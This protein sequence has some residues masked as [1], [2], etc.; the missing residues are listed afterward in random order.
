MII[1]KLI[2]HEYLNEISDIIKLFYGKE[3]IKQYNDSENLIMEDHTV[4]IN[5]CIIK[6]ENQ[7]FFKASYFNSGDD[8]EEDYTLTD[9]GN[10][11]DVKEIKKALKIS[12]YKLLSKM[13]DKELP[14][15]IL[16]GIR[17]VKIVHQ[18][19]EKGHNNDEII[20]YLQDEYYVSEERAL[21]SVRVARTEEKYIREKN[22]NIISIYIGI[23]F[24]PSRCNYCSFTSNSIDKNRNLVQPY[25]DAMM[26]EIREVSKYLKSRGI[27]AQSVYIG[28][29]TPTSI[30]AE[31]LDKL[32]HC[33][34]EFWH[35]C[36]EFTCEA[37]RPDTIDEEKLKVIKS[38]EVTRLSIN[39]QTMDDDTLVRIGRKHTHRQI[40]ESFDLARSLGF[41]N[42][43]MDMILGLPGEGLNQVQNTLE[44][45]KKLNPENVTVHTMAIKRASVYNEINPDLGR[46]YDDMAFKMM[47]LARNSLEKNSYYPYYLYRQK[48][49]A[50]NLENIGFCKKDKECIYNIQIMEEKQSIVAFGADAVTKAFFQE[51][52]RLERQHNIKDLK[53][54]IEKIGEQI[55]KKIELLE[56]LYT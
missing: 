4:F 30:S 17:P 23:P 34:N 11:T 36:E 39:P 40:V 1:L 49:M 18:L 16:T 29:G 32:L 3:S 12:M 42:I 53:L 25:L 35:E 19:L 14:W 10:I 21:L 55:D 8:R 31:E 37:G 48:H 50:Q 52:D 6:A 46:Y 2:G 51:D 56:K 27:K 7:T 41:D 20:K 15:G 24:C 54:Y 13:T 43:N 38:S 5:S 47:E 33:I 28:G 9:K 44:W 45:M 22:N 26:L